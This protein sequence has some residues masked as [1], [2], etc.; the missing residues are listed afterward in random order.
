MDAFG[1]GRSSIHVDACPVRDNILVKKRNLSSTKSPLR[2]VIIRRNIAYLT[3]R[4]IG[5]KSGFYQY[6]VPNGT[7]STNIVSLGST[8]IVSLGSTNIASL[9]FYQYSV[10][11]FYQYSVPW[12]LPI[13]SP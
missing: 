10:P 1:Y 4:G 2:D 9:G 12:F 13:F 5:A 7:G 8:N 6:S 11:W 3:A